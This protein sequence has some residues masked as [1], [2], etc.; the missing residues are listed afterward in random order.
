MQKHRAGQ[1]LGYTVLHE[2]VSRAMEYVHM[3]DC[4]VSDEYPLS[5]QLCD[6]FLALTHTLD[7]KRGTQT[8]AVKGYSNCL[9]KILPYLFVWF[10][11]LFI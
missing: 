4:N 11:F 5:F 8:T 7:Q 2:L 6:L 10:W 1:K 9:F 3:R